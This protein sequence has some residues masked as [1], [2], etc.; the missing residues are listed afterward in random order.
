MPTAEE[1]DHA[2]VNNGSGPQWVATVVNTIGQQ[3]ACAN[4]E[5][6]WHDTAIVI[7]WDDWGGWY[8]HVEPP[9]IRIQPSSPPA[10]GD[11]YT[12]GYRVPMMIVSAFT[13]AGYVD[14][15]MHDFG[16]IL[17]FIEQ[18]FHLGFIGPG[19][20]IYSNYADYQA[21]ARGDGLASFFT[22]NSPRSFVPIPT[23]VNA[24]Y[25]LSRPVSLVSPDND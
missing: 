7:T 22:L 10:W 4:G 1:S 16:T 14:N 19:K 6:Y 5:E 25:F 9:Q 12:F 3:P 13:P 18:N 23:T 11:G 21:A 20:T 15:D 17:D 2:S 8:D 24:R